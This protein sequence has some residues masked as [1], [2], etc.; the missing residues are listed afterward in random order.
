MVGVSVV[1]TPSYSLVHITISF[2]LLCLLSV[3][4]RVY[5]Y[6]RRCLEVGRGCWFFEEVGIVVI[7][8]GVV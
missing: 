3:W 7:A 4:C 5:Q 6:G 1:L 2:D 8:W